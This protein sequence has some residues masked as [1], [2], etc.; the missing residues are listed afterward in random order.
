VT[1]KS[2]DSVELPGANLPDAEPAVVA[3]RSCGSCSLCCKVMPVQELSKP[4]GQWCVHAVP[5]SRYDGFSAHRT[6]PHH[7]RELVNFNHYI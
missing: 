1:G 5:G 7:P 4:A 6:P 3:G 2:Q